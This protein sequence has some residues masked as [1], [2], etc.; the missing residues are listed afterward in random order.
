LKKLDHLSE[1]YNLYDTFII[2]LWGVMHN[3]IKLNQGAIEVIENLEINKKR[4]VFLSNAPRP[5]ENVIDFLRKL[6]M[7]EKFLINVITSGEAAISSLKNYK[8]GKNFYHVGPKR[9]SSLFKGME[10]NKT[11]IEK[12]DFILC[13]GLFDEYKDLNYYRDMFKNSYSKKLICTNPDLTVHRGNE[14]EFCAGKIAEIYKSL[15]GEVIYF[16]KPHKEI[17]DLILKKNEKNLIIGD[18]LN[19]D[20]KGANN[21]EID[22]LFITNGV[23]RAELHNDDL[24][25][26]LQ[27][28]KVKTNFIQKELRW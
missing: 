11:N 12:C 6:K 1:I 21:L 16:G 19:T 4:I 27:Q 28:Y 5:S 18:N 17:Y 8:F 14:E 22:S 23:H 7:K 24:N 25:T 3:G 15:G 10:K 2:D 13:T 20:I 26:V 9:D